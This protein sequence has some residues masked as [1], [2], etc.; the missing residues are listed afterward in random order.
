MYTHVTKAGIVVTVN[1]VSGLV[2]RSQPNR[3]KIV[4]PSLYGLISLALAKPDLS[5]SP[6]HTWKSR[7]N[8]VA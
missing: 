3:M 5:I 4:V 2:S 1:L 6:N 7:G 8:H